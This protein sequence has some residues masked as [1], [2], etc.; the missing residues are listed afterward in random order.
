MRLV[1]V[2]CDNPLSDG[3][4]GPVLGV[5]SGTVDYT[6]GVTDGSFAIVI[7]GLTEMGLVMSAYLAQPHPFRLAAVSKY[8]A[9]NGASE[10]VL[11]TLASHRHGPHHDQGWN[12]TYHLRTSVSD[13]HEAPQDDCATAP[14]SRLPLADTP[15]RMAGPHR[16]TR[17]TPC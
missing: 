7:A 6:L 13:K 9:Q 10:S 8:L 12:R 15:R 2:G 5:G 16:Q 11:T 1:S 14:Y 17:C 3:A 4:D